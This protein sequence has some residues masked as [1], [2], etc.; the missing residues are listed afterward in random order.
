MKTP[1]TPT[2]RSLIPDADF[3]TMKS[4][5]NQ[6]IHELVFVSHHLENDAPE[7]AAQCLMTAQSNLEDLANK[8]APFEEASHG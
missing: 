3:E 2:P 4:S 5:I 1:T 6:T 8:I 7:S